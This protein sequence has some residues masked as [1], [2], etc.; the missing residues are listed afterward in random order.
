[1]VIKVMVYTEWL[2]LGHLPLP[3]AEGGSALQKSHD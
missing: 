2:K 3:G 1:M